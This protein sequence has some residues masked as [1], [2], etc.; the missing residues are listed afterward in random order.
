MIGFFCPRAVLRRRARPAGGLALLRLA[1]VAA[2]ATAL[3]GCAAVMRSATSGLA[4]SLAA[5]MLRQNDPQTVRDGAPAYLLMIDGLIE[6]DPRSTALLLAGAKLY[7]TYAA[8]F[9]NDPARAR[10]L[11]DKAHGYGLRALCT[12]QALLCAAADQPFDQFEPLLAQLRTADAAVLYGFT[13]AWAGRVQ[14]FADDWN[15]VADIPK[16]QASMQRV[17]EL[18]EAHDSGG[19]HVYLGVLATL[20]PPSVGGK[21]Q[22]GRRHFERAVELSQGRSLMF[23]VLFAK[24]YARLMFDRPLHDRLLNEV[25]AAS[26]QVPELTLANTLARQRAQELLASAEEYF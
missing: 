7:G 15:A 12:R 20:L 13:V 22:V 26:P 23:K 2:L 9:V 3:C 6:D 4:D 1:L 18:D 17:L 19:A 5:A 8:A 14:A 24:H 16:V 25:M 10:R 21:P 11:A